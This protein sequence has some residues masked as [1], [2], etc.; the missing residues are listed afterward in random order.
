MVCHSSDIKP[1]SSEHPILIY[2]EFRLWKS[3]VSKRTS[4]KTLSW[5]T[6]FRAYLRVD[7]NSPFSIRL[8]NSL[9]PSPVTPSISTYWIPQSSFPLQISTPRRCRPLLRLF[10]PISRTFSL[11]KTHRSSRLQKRRIDGSVWDAKKSSHIVRDCLAFHT[12]PREK[13]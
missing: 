5:W 8:S 2:L 4:G 12:V 13:Q 1:V 9:R 10:V 11:Y 3:P 7:P 6:F